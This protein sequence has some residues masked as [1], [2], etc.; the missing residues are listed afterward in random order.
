MGNGNKKGQGMEGWSGRG[1]NGNN[2]IMG[3]GEYTIRCPSKFLSCSST[4]PM[5]PVPSFLS[6]CLP[7]P[8]KNETVCPVKP[9]T[10]S[11]PVP[12]VLFFFYPFCLFQV[13]WGTQSSNMCQ[14]A[15]RGEGINGQ[16]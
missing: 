12:S 8:T 13:P 15:R 9:P 11:C 16:S 2:G 1:N 3:N 4:R 10:P 5:P 14:Y 7:P 6:L